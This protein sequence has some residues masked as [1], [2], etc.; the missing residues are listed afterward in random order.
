[1]NFEVV[2]TSNVTCIKKRRNYKKALNKPG[3][4]YVA[5]IYVGVEDDVQDNENS[6][7][8]DDAERCRCCSE[9]ITSTPDGARKKPLTQKFIPDG[10]Q[11]KIT[12]HYIHLLLKRIANPIKDSGQKL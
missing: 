4:R 7:Y 11:K 5:A 12:N 6:E 10:L 2:V 3:G 1:M 8:V 9:A